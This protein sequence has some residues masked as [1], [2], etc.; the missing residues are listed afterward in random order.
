M[1][2]RNQ[3]EI[4]DAF[5]RREA[6]DELAR[7]LEALKDPD[8]FYARMLE[9]QRAETRA[10]ADR[11]IGYA[12]LYGAARGELRDNPAA[13]RR[14]DGLAAELFPEREEHEGIEPEREWARG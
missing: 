2:T 10:A 9:T 11:A 8:R 6:A 14:L 4:I 13:V 7:D 5:A 3:E 12:A 1:Q